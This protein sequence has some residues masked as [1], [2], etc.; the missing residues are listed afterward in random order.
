MFRLDDHGLSGLT[1]TFQLFSQ[2]SFQAFN[3]GELLLGISTTGGDVALTI[4]HDLAD[5]TEEE[6]IEQEGEENHLNRHQR[7]GGIEVKKTSLRNTCFS[8]QKPGHGM[9]RWKGI[10]TRSSEGGSAIPLH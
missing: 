5:R 1:G 4:F 6:D 8:E 2:I 9:V 3:L 7:K 10:E